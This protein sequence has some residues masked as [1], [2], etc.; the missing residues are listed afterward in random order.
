MNFIIYLHMPIS[1]TNG[2]ITVQLNLAKSLHEKGMNT[3]LISPHGNVEN[4]IYSNFGSIND[5]NDNTFVIYCDGI[6]GNPLNAKNVIRW[7]LYGIQT[8]VSSTF[9]DTDIIYYFLP[10]CKQNILRNKLTFMYLNPSA[11]NKHLA[12]HRESCFI[13]KK[14]FNYAKNSTNL[15]VFGSMK[16]PSLIRSLRSIQKANSLNIE[17]LSTQEEYIEIFNTTKYFFCY[18]PVCFLVILALMCGCVVIQDPMAGY[19][20]EEW[21][22]TSFGSSNRIK[23]L[24]YG[25]ENLQYAIATIDEAPQQCKKLI[26]S[27]N[28]S[29]D[30]F[31]QQIRDK[32]YSTE[33][34]YDFDSSPYSF[35]H[36]YYKNKLMNNNVGFY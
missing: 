26:E 4:T 11:Y 9:L 12:R 16:K 33:K 36:G 28:S 3:K 6:K 32:T 27:N 2:G 35:Q 1:L 31:I 13:V 23:G 15:R 17:Y 21:L 10:F 20:E 19:S 22:K 29:I 30:T 18:D 7:L 8:E 24:A 5:I 34:C 14:G 25:V